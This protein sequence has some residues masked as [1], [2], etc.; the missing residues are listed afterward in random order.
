VIFK[1]PD[2]NMGDLNKA[3][4][5]RSWIVRASGEPVPPNYNVVLKREL[6]LDTDLSANM[7]VMTLE[8]WAD[9]EF[10]ATR[11]DSLS[12]ALRN[13]L[14]REG[15]SADI[16]TWFLIDKQPPA[17]ILRMYKAY[18]EDAPVDSYPR[19]SWD[20]GWFQDVVITDQ[21]KGRVNIET[22]STPANPE[23]Y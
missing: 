19:R 18:L 22:T 8:G 12:N 23:F 20:R 3:L 6:V 13:W 9:F 7:T 5:Y 14:S 16:L 10:S 11:Q 17:K 2:L 1:A 4:G 15:I 21:I